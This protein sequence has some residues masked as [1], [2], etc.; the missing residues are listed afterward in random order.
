LARIAGAL[1]AECGV[2]VR[3]GRKGSGAIVKKLF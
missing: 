2:R 1:H 3:E